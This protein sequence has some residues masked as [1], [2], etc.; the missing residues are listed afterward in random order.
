MPIRLNDSFQ[1]HVVKTVA[2]NSSARRVHDLLKVAGKCGK[3]NDLMMEC[4]EE[5][6]ELICS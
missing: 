3:S 6:E 1:E 4:E 5:K 2:I